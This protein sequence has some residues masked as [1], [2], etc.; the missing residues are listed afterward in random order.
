MANGKS[1]NFFIALVF[2]K[3][4]LTYIIPRE[5]T[6]GFSRYRFLVRILFGENKS[7]Q[8]MQSYTWISEIRA[9]RTFDDYSGH[10]YRKAITRPN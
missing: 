10:T 2:N 9:N 8:I 6:I 1:N 7:K 5:R 4:L 3:V